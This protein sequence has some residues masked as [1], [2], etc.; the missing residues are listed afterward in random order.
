MNKL[1]R[2]A[3][4]WS[5]CTSSC[6]LSKDKRR[7]QQI[8]HQLKIRQLPKQASPETQQFLL[9]LIEQEVFLQELMDFHQNHSGELE[10]RIADVKHK[11]SLLLEFFQ[12]G[13]Q[14]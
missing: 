7:K 12:R 14:L 6:Y 8:E 5:L 11:F 2:Y 13:V 1:A 4:I 10:A 9:G 3:A